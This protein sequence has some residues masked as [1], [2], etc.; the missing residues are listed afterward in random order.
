MVARG[1]GDLRPS[2]QRASN[3]TASSRR[4]SLRRPR[5]GV[6]CGRLGHRSLLRNALCTPPTTRAPR[7]LV[8]RDW[9]PSLWTSL[10]SHCD[11]SP[12]PAAQNPSHHFLSGSAES[13]SGGNHV[14]HIA[15]GALEFQPAITRV[16]LEW[17]DDVGPRRQQRGIQ[18]LRSVGDEETMLRACYERARRFTNLASLFISRDNP[19]QQ[20]EARTIYFRVTGKAFNSQPPP[21]LYTRD[22][23]WEVAEEF[24]WESDDAQ[25]GDAVEGRLRGL[26]LEDSRIDARI[27]SQAGL[28]YLEWT[29]QFRNHSN[30]QQEARTQILLPP[31]GLVSRLTLWVNGE[32]REAAFAGRGQV[33]QAYE[34][35]VRQRRDPVL[36]TTQGK[37]RILVQCFPVPPNGGK[38]Q[39]RI[40]MTVPLQMLDLTR[41]TLLLPHMVERNFSL[42]HGLEHA[43]WVESRNPLSSPLA[44]LL[45]SSK[46]ES[47]FK[48]HGQILNHELVSPQA[49]IEVTRP[50]ATK[51]VWTRD[52]T[53]R[54]LGLRPVGHRARW[55]LRHGAFLSRDRHS[56]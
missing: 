23:R 40:G 52:P 13:H 15:I 53:K 43:L 38:M 18:I 26:S 10:R 51:R 17:A 56:A 19:L 55:L 33:R 32:E 6:Q 44:T 1:L 54:R 14:R 21:R 31:D 16:A 45:S 8:L 28:A 34:N 11:L 4:G 2:R 47:E 50:E 29:L 42:A 24:S 22:G 36:V 7:D 9:S 3:P 46:G 37:D 12:A 49:A 35:I 30:R 48:L 41:G 25:G 39:T 20:L 5:S 27:H